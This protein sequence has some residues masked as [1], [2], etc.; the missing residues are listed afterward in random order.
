MTSV[1]LLLAGSVIVSRLKPVTEI[2]RTNAQRHAWR[3]DD[4]DDGGGDEEEGEKRE[5]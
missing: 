1:T 3:P 4:D 2:Q 5:N